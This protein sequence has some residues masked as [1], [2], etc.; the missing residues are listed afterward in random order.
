MIKNRYEIQYV[1]HTC[2]S[3]MLL[4]ILQGKLYRLLIIFKNINI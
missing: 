4:V 2:Y 1:D 3:H